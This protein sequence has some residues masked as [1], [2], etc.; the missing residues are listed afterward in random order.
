MWKGIQ[1]ILSD[2][3]DPAEV[4]EDLQSAYEKSAK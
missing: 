4:A 2:Q 3:S 1:G